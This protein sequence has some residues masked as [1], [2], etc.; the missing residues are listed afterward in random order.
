MKRLKLETPSVLTL[1]AV[2]I[3]FGSIAPASAQADHSADRN[4][5]LV[6]TQWTVLNL[7]GKP[8]PDEDSGLYFD[9]KQV[10]R[11]SGGSTGQLV[12]PSSDGCND[13]TGTYEVHGRSLHIDFVTST[14]V[15]C[16]PA[17]PP[18]GK[19]ASVQRSRPFGQPEFIEVL[20]QT[21]SFKIRSSTL[22]L[23]NK[24]GEVVANL[25]ASQD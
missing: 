7:K 5:R 25:T 3:C 12:S 13:L 9:L 23:M 19:G 8:V 22:E 24:N 6:G 20:R 16:P 1:L 11:F 2:F 18:T 14:L 15:A 10:Q 17:R 4:L 21:A